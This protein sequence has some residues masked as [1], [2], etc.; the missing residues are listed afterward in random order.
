MRVALYARVSTTDQNLD[1]QTVALRQWLEALG[2]EV[3]AVYAESVSG[4]KRERELQD[5]LRNNL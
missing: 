1:V 4:G 3:V 5:L 2:H